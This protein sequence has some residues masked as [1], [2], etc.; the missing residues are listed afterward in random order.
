[1]E[2]PRLWLSMACQDGQWTI[3]R[4]WLSVGVVGIEM[5]RAHARL[6]PSCTMKAS[7]L[8][9]LLAVKTV[10]GQR[11]KSETSCRLPLLLTSVSAAPSP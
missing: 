2:G 6:L 5:Y 8:M 9:Q 10:H 7:S 3:G 11:V 4:S 1:M